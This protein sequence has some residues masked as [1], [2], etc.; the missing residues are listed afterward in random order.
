M[1]PSQSR[2]LRG[3]CTFEGCLCS[4]YEEPTTDT[5]DCKRCKHWDLLHEELPGAIISSASPAPMPN[6][7]PQAAPESQLASTPAPAFSSSAAT[8]V[9]GPPSV[10]STSSASIQGIF[11][12]AAGAAGR[13]KV[14]GAKPHA[15]GVKQ[16]A[17]HT[18]SMQ[19]YRPVCSCP[20]S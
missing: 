15:V 19:G 1:A 11:A 10:S 4:S 6:P 16:Q 18:E 20:R 13:S 2:C 3:T 9:P 12:K 14:P 17:A 5:L 7:P 8:S